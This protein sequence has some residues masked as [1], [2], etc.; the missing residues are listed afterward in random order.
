M[1]FQIIDF[2]ML[3]L[4]IKDDSQDDNSKQFLALIIVSGAKFVGYLFVFFFNYKVYSQYEGFLLAFHNYLVSFR[5][6][7]R[8]KLAKKYRPHLETLVEEASV[9]EKS[10]SNYSEIQRMDSTH[11]SNYHMESNSGIGMNKSMKKAPMRMSQPN[12]TQS[13]FTSVTQKNYNSKNS[14]IINNSQPEEDSLLDDSGHRDY[15]SQSTKFV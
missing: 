9:M 11:F 4:F 6:T 14:Q 1:I 8:S 13:N 3:F 12:Q 5:Q 15:G 2:F 7:P 10:M